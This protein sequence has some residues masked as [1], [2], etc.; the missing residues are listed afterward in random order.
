MND[1]HE[2]RSAEYRRAVAED[3]RAVRK[4]IRDE[5]RRRAVTAEDWGTFVV[6]LVMI[7]LVGLMIWFG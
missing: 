6:A 5:S 4:Y 3:L 1:D 2:R 7:G